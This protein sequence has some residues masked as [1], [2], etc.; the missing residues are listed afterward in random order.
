MKCNTIIDTTLQ[1]IHRKV[2]EEKGD[3]RVTEKDEKCERN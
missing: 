1:Y 3:V 2:E